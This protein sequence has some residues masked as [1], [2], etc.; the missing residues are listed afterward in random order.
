MT[1]LRLHV[2]VSLALG[3][4]VI[5]CAIVLT[6]LGRTRGHHGLEPGRTVPPQ[7]MSLLDTTEARGTHLILFATDCSWCTRQVAALH[8][9]GPSRT[10]LRVV[11]LRN[12]PEDAA[13]VPLL[14]PWVRVDGVSRQ[15]LERKVGR[16]GT[17]MHLL[18]DATGRIRLSARGF[19]SAET[20]RRMNALE[21]FSR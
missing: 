15:D 21:A 20:L 7:L 2:F 9:A 10:Q 4:S 8:E 14:P 1:G 12:G 19:K 6:A 3:V 17:P 16:V 5:G 18:L 11:V 13:P